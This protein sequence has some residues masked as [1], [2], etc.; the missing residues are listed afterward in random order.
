M[1]TTLLRMMVLA[2]LAMTWT[3]ASAAPVDLADK[4]MGNSIDPAVKPNV[5]FILDK[6]GSMSWS[7]MPDNPVA[8]L[9]TKYGYK[10]S[11]C[12]GVYYNPSVTYKPPVKAD[13]TSYPDATFTSAWNNGFN[14]TQGTVNLNTSFRAYADGTIAGTFNTLSGAATGNDTAQPAYYYQYNGAGGSAGVKQ[15]AMSYVIDSTGSVNT[16]SPPAAG[17]TNFYPECNQSAGAG[18]AATS[19]WTKVILTTASPAAD[20]KNFANWY[21][22]YRTRIQMMKSATG[23][24]FSQLNDPTAL[25]L[26]LVY[27]DLGTFLPIANY[28]DTT[29]VTHITSSCSSGTTQRS[30]LY[31]YL[32]AASPASG[33]P[34]RTALSK[35][36]QMYSGTGSFVGTG[37]PDPVLYSCQRNVAILAT[38]GFWNSDTPGTSFPSVGNADS[39][40]IAPYNDTSP[41]SSNSM[42]DIAAYFYKTDL[43]TSGGLS[44]NNVRTSVKDPANWQHMVTFT[45]GLGANGVRK[46]LDGYENETA[47]YCA[48]HPCSDYLAIS[49]GTMTWPDPTPTENATRMDDLWHAAVNGRGTYFA[50]NTVESLANGLKKSL[51]EAAA[52]GG[53]GAAATGNL[54]PTTGD[55]K[56]YLASYKTEEWIGNVTQNDIDPQTGNI[57]ATA[58]WSA[59]AKLDALVATAPA[60]RKIYW[61]KLGNLAD[62]TA[63]Q[64]T[65]QITNHLF[66]AGPTN[67]NGQL[68]QYQFFSAAQQTAATPASV[69]AFIRGERDLEDVNNDTLST[70]VAKLYRG[71]THV[72]GDIVNGAPVYVKKPAFD[73]KDSGYS[74]FV[75][76][77][78]SRQGVVY[79]SANDGMLHAFNADT[80]DEM[81]AFVPTYALP[82]LYKLADKNYANKHRPFV[83]GP[84]TVADADFGAG[85]WRT[86]L[87]GGLGKGGRA[88]FALDITDPSNPTLLWE[89]S[90]TTSG[91]SS[92]TTI[93]DDLGYTF[94]GAQITKLNGGQWV[95]VFASGYNNTSPGTGDAR[96][97]VVNLANGTKVA[98]IPTSGGTNP[99]LSGIA[100]VN[101]WTD[102]GMTDNSVK[103]VYAG[104]LSGRV[105]RFDLVAQT[106]TLLTTVGSSAMPQPITTRPE[107]GDFGNDV[108]QRVVY[109]GT[110]RYLGYSDVANVDM[111]SLYAIRDD[112]NT[113]KFNIGN[114]YFRSVA[115]VLSSSNRNSANWN[116]NQVSTNSFGWY[117]DFNAQNGERVTVHPRLRGDQRTLNVITN[118]PANDKCDVGGASYAYFLDAQASKNYTAAVSDVVTSV[119][120]ALSVGATPMTLESGKQVVVITRSDG[121][122]VTVG[123]GTPGYGNAVRRVSWR[124]LKN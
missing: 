65:S 85:G 41:A 34:T 18:P 50:A 31:C 96:L 105:W 73:F 94:G 104:D 4:P 60:T 49:G 19:T 35:T 36:G 12:N 100:W 120:S 61:A 33:T 92:T 114:P 38:D 7:H 20:Q 17:A 57:S 123:G 79:A 44:N 67:P 81:W 103:H 37:K 43:R 48:S 23:L 66:D 106:A 56:A 32:Y 110:G 22:Y 95:A 80:G 40:G 28:G 71:R 86:I 5:M 119:G 124:E 3:A 13:G 77:K 101:G 68:E 26:G 21:S 93:D 98:E 89:F 9:R 116:F 69:I 11:Q 64:L 99:S 83:D 112:S 88:Y 97:Y 70:N 29:G 46:Y 122:T 75:T 78:A 113:L 1:R 102:S 16:S 6:S 24:A 2:S 51:A 53:G 42:A 76:A 63:A 59:Q 52:D 108:N 109:V 72:L 10:S 91:T 90:A 84:I 118:V 8:G 47:A 121:Q 25:R 87:I 107:L 39:A 82:N 15:P 30:R 54:A 58:N 62:F 115:A 74:A 27:H 45:L 117:L 14:T 111:Q 55:N